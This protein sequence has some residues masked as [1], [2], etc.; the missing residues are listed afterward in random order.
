MP[1]R[2]I[3]FLHLIIIRSVCVSSVLL[4]IF[5]GFVPEVLL[6]CFGWLSYDQVYNSAINC[7]DTKSQWQFLI[8]VFG[9]LEISYISDLKKILTFLMHIK[10]ESI[11]WLV[12][13]VV[14]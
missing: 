11:E 2:I 6:I 10:F 3:I 7:T 8:I 9:K 4:P 1:F 14:Y 13:S 5:V 12:C